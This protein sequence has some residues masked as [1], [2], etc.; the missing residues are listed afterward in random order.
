[1]QK[2]A[3]FTRLFVVKVGDVQNVA[4]RSGDQCAKPKWAKAVIDNPSLRLG[5]DPPRER[6]N[7]SK[8]VTTETI[9]LHVTILAEPGSACPHR[10]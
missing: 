10:G 2:G 7:T 4:L 1:L 3:K 8:E 5:H 9:V 6:P